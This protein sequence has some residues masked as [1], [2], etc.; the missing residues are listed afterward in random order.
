MRLL[1]AHDAALAS[2]HDVFKDHPRTAVTRV[3]DGDA[4]FCVKEYRRAGW[5][6]AAKRLLRGS[7]ATR[8]WRGAARLA[9]AGLTTPEPLAVAE[10]GRADY[11]VTRYVAGTEALDLLLADRFGG[12]LPQAEIAAKREL[13]RS[14][15]PWLRRAHD[16]GVYH[17]DWSAKNILA[18]ERGGRW[19]FYFLDFESV[20]GRKRLT[21]RRRAKNLAQLSDVPAGATRTDKMRFLLAYARGARA[22]TR[23]RFPREVVAMARRRRAARERL[24]ARDRAR[25]AR[26]DE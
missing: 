13:I 22:L 11:L 4:C 14:L 5:L 12:A 19:H 1:A 10:R 20:S 23:G 9:L 7:R 26:G 3:C 17:D 2:G 15:A 16:E 24:I 25:R 21:W 6:D 18:A 8:A